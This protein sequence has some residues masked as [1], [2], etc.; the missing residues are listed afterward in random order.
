MSISDTL[1]QIES[2]ARWL[3]DDAF[4]LSFY[5]RRL[6]ARRSFETNAEDALTTAE[7]ELLVALDRVRRAKAE[8]AAKPV[9]DR[10]A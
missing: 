6:P 7:Q 1:S 9:N 3:R 10:V 4:N 8:Y 2:K 5:V